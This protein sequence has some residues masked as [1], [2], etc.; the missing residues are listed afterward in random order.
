MNAAF[1]EFPNLRIK[2]E[3]DFYDYFIPFYE[4]EKCTYILP[5]FFNY[6]Y[7]MYKEFGL[8]KTD[9]KMPK[10]MNLR[11]IPSQIFNFEGALKSNIIFIAEGWCDA[12]S[13]E[14]PGYN[15]LALNGV[16]NINLFINKL[17]NIKDYHY[18]YCIIAF[19][20]D[21]PGLIASKKLSKELLNMKFKV[22]HLYSSGY[23]VKDIND[24]LLKN[25]IKLKSELEKINDCINKQI[26]R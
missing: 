13:I 23:K 11:G 8:L 17:K 2:E 22:E 1:K 21:K 18:K 12:L 15:S 26:R 24:M 3:N 4:N 25:K 14:T 20:S 9:V 10:I 19:D 7:N 6:N 16:S 5:I